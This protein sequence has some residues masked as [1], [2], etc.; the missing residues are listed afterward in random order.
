[1]A[2][3]IDGYNLLHVSRFA[4]TGRRSDRLRT[5]RE[6]LLEYLASNVPAHQYSRVN[7]VFDSERPSR[8]LP[9]RVSFKHLHVHFATDHP[10][11]DDLI[12]DL[13]RGEPAPE[14]LLVVSSDHRLQAAAKRRGA[15]F[16]DSDAWIEALDGLHGD[17]PRID[18]ESEELGL[19]THER[20]LEKPVELANPFPE[21]YAE[22][23]DTENL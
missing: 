1:M 16:I 6:K 17:R 3:I 5:A 23:L 8:R 4:P 19:A 18:R 13:I 21:G 2:L 15:K 20:N 14:K 9:D 12:E 22:D 10:R 11:A 7:I